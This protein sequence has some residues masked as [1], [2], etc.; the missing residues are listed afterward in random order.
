MASRVPESS[1]I[2]KSSLAPVAPTVALTPRLAPRPTPIDDQI[3][4]A[5]SG[6]GLCSSS[7]RHVWGL[8]RIATVADTS[9]GL[10]PDLSH[11][12]TELGLLQCQL[13]SLLQQ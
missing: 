4:F 6:S 12:Q 2:I 11:I 8:P 1:E 7:G 3:A 13:G 5:A 9:P 10:V